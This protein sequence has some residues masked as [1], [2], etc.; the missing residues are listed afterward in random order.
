MANN[1]H[2]SNLVHACSDVGKGGLNLI[3]NLAKP[4]TCMPVAYNSSTKTTVC[5]R[6]N[7]TYYN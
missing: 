1:C 6:N 3:L 7:Q 5:E 4:H 2:N